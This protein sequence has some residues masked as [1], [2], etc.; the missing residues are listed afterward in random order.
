MTT[1]ELL[2]AKK[3]LTDIAFAFKKSRILFTASELNIFNI[4][5]RDNLTAN[6]IA[7]ETNAE[8]NS[9]KR[10]LNALVAADI[11]EKKDDL[12]ANTEA[13]KL[14]LVKDS[15]DYMGRIL[16]ISNVWNVWS[17]LTESIIQ[18]KPVVYE[19]FGEKDEAWI[20]SVAEG[21]QWQAINEAKD[22]IKNIDFKNAEKILIIGG[23][24]GVYAKEMLEINPNLKITLFCHP[25][26]GRYSE[27]YLNSQGIGD[28]VEVLTGDIFTDSF[29]NANEYDILLSSHLISL[30]PVRDNIELFKKAYFYVAYGGTI[31]IHEN[32]IDDSRTKPLS[33][34]LESINM[35]VNTKSG[36]VYTHTEIWVML[37]ESQFLD[38][39]NQ[40]TNVGTNI[41]SAQKY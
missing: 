21:I 31:Y 19:E 9:I 23:E 16:N 39:E 17:N 12:Y 11:L 4:I 27:K 22:V 25:R 28:K 40:A 15:S 32:V 2:K 33:A 36:E 6:E 18:G 34:T 38:I 37:R 3:N 41:I 35:L 24:I 7:E 20:K 14:L 1:R 8:V 30:H 13:S 29:G 10:L 26:L 5:S